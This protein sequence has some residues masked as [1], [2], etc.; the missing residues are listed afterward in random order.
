MLQELTGA[1]CDYFQWQPFMYEELASFDILIFIKYIPEF[2]ILKKLNAQGVRM[3]L[4]YQDTFLYPSVYEPGL[5]RR[6]LKQIYYARTER[7]L[8]A[9]FRLLDGCLYAAPQL[10]PVL[11]RTGLRPLFLPRQ[12]YNDRSAS[13]W[14]SHSSQTHGV[15]LYWTG[16]SL[17]QQQNDPILPVLRQ[18]KKQYGCRILYDTD[19][20][21]NHDWIEYRS[22]NPDTWDLDILD[23]DIAFRWRDTSSMQRFKDPNKLLGYMAAGLPAVVHPTES[24]KQIASHGETAMF[25]RT[26]E[27]FETAVAALIQDPTL[28][29]RI[30]CK[31]HEVAWAGHSLQKHT[32]I[33]AEH[34]TSLVMHGAPNDT[35]IREGG[36]HA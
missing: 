7:Q 35:R 31:A 26:V 28:R 33:L 14:K 29:A 13:H 30:G 21:G 9:A 10:E 20:P 15:T 2:S 1:T 4:D 36:E 8:S 5:P 18:L 3:L 19:A 12:I 6:M 27:E 23:A 34:L 22:F 17:N 32:S 25:V 24:E 11:R 16:V